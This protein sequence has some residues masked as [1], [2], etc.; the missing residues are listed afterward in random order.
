MINRPN[1]IIKEYEPPCFFCP[2]CLRIPIIEIFNIEPFTINII[3]EFCQNMQ[4][5]EYRSYLNEIE[6]I[7]IIK[8][9]QVHKNVKSEKYCLTCFIWIC[10]D[11]CSNHVQ[12]NHKVYDNPYD[13]NFFCYLHNKNNFEFYCFLCKTHLCKICKD[14]HKGHSL[15]KLDEIVKDKQFIVNQIENAENFVENDCKK[16]YEEKIEEVDDIFQKIEDAYQS[17]IKM[18]E[19]VKELG[20]ILIEDFERGNKDYLSE[21]NL[22]NNTNY[23]YEN[24]QGS[25]PEELIDFYKTAFILDD[26]KATNPYNI[27]ID[28]IL[29][30]PQA[31]EEEKIL[32][33]SLHEVKCII[34]LDEDYIIFTDKNEINF[35]SIKDNKIIR[36]FKGHT[37]EVTFLTKL[38]SNTI[39]SGGKDFLIKSWDIK[40]GLEIFSFSGHNEYIIGIV[41]LSEVGFISCSEDRTLMFWEKEKCT[42]VISKAHESSIKSLLLINNNLT[43]VSAEEEGPLKFWNLKEKKCFQQISDISCG[44]FDSLAG[45]NNNLLICGGYNKIQIVSCTSF[46]VITEIPCS[47]RITS[48]IKIFDGTL[49]FS[50]LKG[51]FYHLNLETKEMKLVKEKAHENSINKIIK[52]NENNFISCSD[53]HLIKLWR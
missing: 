34:V 46:E 20:E 33:Q 41:K 48:F 11:C 26:N 15:K 42:K 25:T 53:D 28:G 6:S 4:R 44:C 45:I 30:N 50:S 27:F 7:L 13:H 18:N 10:Q 32:F 36:Q 23:K 51:D 22:I 3:C 8:N 2:K 49:V 38:T 9:C 17:G 5:F 35:F 43:L 31:I 37:E 47:V 40:K 12:N 29:I 14:I 19:R 16:L 21:I 39:L 1:K 24:F 52:I